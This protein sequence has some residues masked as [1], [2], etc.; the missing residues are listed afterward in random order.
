MQL[1]LLFFSLLIFTQCTQESIREGK[2]LSLMDKN[3]AQA[4]VNEQIKAINAYDNH[5]LLTPEIEKHL[6][7]FIN[8][9]DNPTRVRVQAVKTLMESGSDEGKSAVLMSLRRVDKNY[10]D[11]VIS[12]LR[13]KISL[14]SE[15][16]REL[17]ASS[18]HYLLKANLLKVLLAE[19]FTPSPELY[20]LVLKM[21]FDAS[22]EVVKNAVLFLGQKGH[23][24]S[25]KL[26]KNLMHS[27]TT[28]MVRLECEKAL[29]LMRFRLG[30]KAVKNVPVGFYEIENKRKPKT[31]NDT[32]NIIKNRLTAELS[33]SELFV[34]LERDKLNNA[35]REMK[36][37]SS[38]LFDQKKAVQLGQLL[39]ARYILYGQ[40][41][42]IQEEKIELSL[43]ILDVEKG[44]YLGT[45]VVN[46]YENNLGSIVNKIVIDVLDNYLSDSKNYI[47]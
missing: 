26:V 37:S 9:T 39:S 7:H 40:L 5:K 38:A 47:K 3:F 20:S 24:D 29:A 43:N 1:K 19:D 34:L 42:D 17:L 36:L 46:G 33:T 23:A 15:K 16:I 27:T 13:T 41:Y 6:L 31:G 21:L 11:I 35:L 14:I 44:K 45:F 8:N 30:K 28:L 32:A 4:A 10:N 25:I 22:D 12:H 18:D 2:T